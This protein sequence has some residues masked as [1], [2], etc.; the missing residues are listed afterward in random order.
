MSVRQDCVI[1]LQKIVEEKAFF[2]N[3]KNELNENDMPFANMLVLTVLRHLPGLQN[4]LNRFVRRKIP[5]KN[6]VLEYV[7]LCACAELL[8][9]ETPDYAAINEYVNLAKKLT[10]RFAAGMAN[11]VLRKICQQKTSLKIELT[12]LFPNAFREMLKGDYSGEEIALM[13]KQTA[14]EPPLDI[15]VKDNPAYWAETL[16]GML[17]ASGTVR[18][19]QPKGKISQLIGFNEGSWWVQDAAAA[20]PVIM[21]GDVN[22]KKVLDLCAAPGGKTMQLLAR[23]ANVCAVDIDSTRMKRLEQNA[24]RLGLTKNLKTVVADAMAFLQN[25][26]QCFD[27]IVVDAPCSATGTFRRHPEVLHIKGKQDVA[28]QLTVQ[29]GLLDAA[30]SK[31]VPEGIIL[32]CTCSVAKAEGEEQIARFLNKHRDF[33]LKPAHWENINIVQSGLFFE[34]NIIDKGVLRT[35]P[36]YIS[37][38]GGMDA[39]FAACV[40]KKI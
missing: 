20:L 14:T 28:T 33:L 4:I 7:L 35:L 6:K 37:N 18:L 8:C 25:C 31:V 15:S 3:L 9:V 24:Q 36:Y 29:Q 19:M 17:L 5:A 12:P 10:D 38:I 22:G 23:G 32:Y 40:Q 26:K 30:V 21:L 1:I 13:E 27:V 16:Q 39:F 2:S 11:A 34:K